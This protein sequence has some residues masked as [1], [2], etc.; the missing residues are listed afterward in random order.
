MLFVKPSHGPGDSHGRRESLK[1]A[2]YWSRVEHVSSRTGPH[3]S[4]LLSLTLHILP[5]FFGLLLFPM[6]KL[7]QTKKYTSRAVVWQVSI[8]LLSN[9]KSIQHSPSW[10]YTTTKFS[11]SSIEKQMMQW[12]KMNACFDLYYTRELLEYAI[13]TLLDRLG[14]VC[15]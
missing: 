2:G 4:S 12:I 5:L 11:L 8:D 7:W 1:I 15:G 9:Y 13:N 3:D 10:I 6:E 14:M